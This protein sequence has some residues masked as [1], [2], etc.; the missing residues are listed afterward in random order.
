VKILLWPS[1]YFPAIGGVELMTRSLAK[2]FHKQGHAVAVF[3]DSKNSN[4]LRE[5]L[6]DGIRV[7]YFPFQAALNSKN[8]ALL[9]NVLHL[10]SEKCRA[11]DPDI[12]NVHGWYEFFS[13]FQVRVLEKIPTFLTIHGLLGWLHHLGNS[14]T[15]LWSMA[16]AIN[17]VSNTLIDQLAG[18]NFHHPRLQII[19]NGIDLGSIPPVLEKGENKLAMIGRFTSEKCFDVGLYAFKSL[20][21]LLPRATL[22]LA[23]NGHDWKMLT[24]LR[25]Q[26][27]L[28][29]SV[30]MPGLIHPDQIYSIIDEANILWIPSLYESFCL[31]AIEA[32]A[33]RR[34]VIA[35]NVFGLKEV[36]EDGKT[37][38]LVQANDPDILAHASLGLLQDSETRM[39]MGRN[40]R[41]RVEEKFSI[42]RCANEYLQMYQSA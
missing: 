20:K 30:Q 21:R 26:L 2:E 5:N 16:R 38:L 32:A 9:K 8:P 19:Y 33:R 36:V 28:E 25:E 11:F 17:T 4:P 41:K 7:Y 3:A 13:F 42:G 18:K 12:A 39:K 27:E 14:C 31:V 22:I 35:N 23:G 34:S 10:A 6:V 1:H 37:G 24:S 15:R 29:D 40:G